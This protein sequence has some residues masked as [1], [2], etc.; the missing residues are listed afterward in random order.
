MRWA[1]LASLS[2]AFGLVLAVRAEEKAGVRVA[3][4]KEASS[5]PAEYVGAS[6]CLGCHAEKESF[7][8][9]LHAHSFLNAK[10]IE[11]EKSCETCHGP[12]S[13]HAAAGGDKSNPDFLTIKNPTRGKATEG[14]ATCLQCH[15]GG[16]RTHWKGSIHEMKNVGCQ[17]CHSMHGDKV[18][19]GKAPLLAKASPAETCYQCHAEKKAQIKKSGHMPLV[20]GKMGCNGCHNAHGSPSEKL[21]VK[22]NVMETCFTCHQDK[23]GPFLWDHA[24]AREGQCAFCHDPHGSHNEKM[25]T[26]RSPFL[27]QRCLVG[28]RHPATAYGFSGGDQISNRLAYKGCVN[29]HFQVHGSN[30]PSGKW[31]NR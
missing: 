24:P 23:R 31:L 10:N 5:S 19:H 6:T 13:L 17:S 4:T 9:N 14:A 7:K 15:E 3:E 21:L 30:H 28:G 26:A 1:S 16:H 20:E 12:G 11:F 29:C 27:C 2:A 8:K 22:N 18:N 25:L